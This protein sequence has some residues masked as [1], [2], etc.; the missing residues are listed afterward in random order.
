MTP[1]S[2]QQVGRLF[3][4]AQDLP[5]DE[6]TAFL[7][8]ECAGDPALRAELDDLFVS[9][10]LAAREAFLDPPRPGREPRPATESTAADAAPSASESALDSD[11]Y[12]RISV[13]LGDSPRPDSAVEQLFHRRLRIGILVIL[14][15]F[16]VFLVKNLFDSHYTDVALRPVLAVHIGVAVLAA[17][18]TPIL[19]RRR[20]WTMSQLRLVEAVL[21]VGATAFFAMYQAGEFQ[22]ESWQLLA[23]PGQEM[24][25]LDNASDSCLL[26]WC[27]LLVFYGFFIPNTWGRCA[28]VL[29]GVVVIPFVVT[30]LIGLS[31]GSLWRFRDVL[32]EMAIWL[33]LALSMAVYGSHKITQLRRQALEGRKLGP[34][35]L[36]ERLGS[37]GMGEVWLAKH[38]LLKRR[39]AIKLIRSELTDDPMALA[40]F[41]REVDA[42]AMLAHPNTVQVFDYGIAE[43]GTFYYTMEYLPGLTL[44]DL[45]RRFGPLPAAR[46]VY[47]LRRACS[48]L[49]EAHAMGLIHRDLK[50]G[51]FIVSNMGGVP[52]V[53][54]LLDF[55]LVRTPAVGPDS[56]PLIAQSYLGGTPAYLP[57]EQT[58]GRRDADARGDVYSLGAVGYFLLSGRPPFEAETLAGVMVAHLQ[59][60]VPSLQCADRQIPTDVEAVIRRCLAKEPTDRYPDMSS[61]ERALAA[62]GCADDW[63][64]HSATLWWREHAPRDVFP[65]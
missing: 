23:A 17:A 35:Q 46:A 7:D 20:T 6:R 41:Q 40:R 44:E 58:I 11:R 30:I 2:W 14:F 37:G 12:R 18:L 43:D 36:I 45:V 56:E 34:Y 63:D 29:G 3:A 52:D 48:A 16:G 60:A 31:E 10:E 59:R 24:E 53:L 57:P 61:L 4:A 42:T 38:H 19:W 21:L 9:D 26:R 50:P 5:R 27:A 22:R 28:A 51:N 1:E 64:E 8:R 39:C 62:C 47:F 25:V 65:A 49:R 13:V 55:G 15:G 54:K 33:G 32:S